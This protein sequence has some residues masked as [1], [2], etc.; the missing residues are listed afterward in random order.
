VPV[1]ATLTLGATPA[2]VALSAQPTAFPPGQAM[3]RGEQT[4][5][6]AVQQTASVPSQSSKDFKKDSGSP[7]TPSSP[8][9]TQA[10]TTTKALDPP[11]VAIVPSPPP[12]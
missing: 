11:S 12:E 10:T 3:Q 7:A 1:Q 4:S 8:P 2:P 6:A 9:A 5:A